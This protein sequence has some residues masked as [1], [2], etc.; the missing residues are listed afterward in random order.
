[1][2]RP[3]RDRDPVKLAGAGML[4]LLG[5]VG[6]AIGL[7][8]AVF[9]QRTTDYAVEL[10]NAAGLRPDDQVFI[11]GVPSGRVRT[12]DLAVDRVR[13]G[14]R[15]DHDQTLGTET[16]AG[17]KLQTILGKRYLDV[18]P[19]GGG[20]IPAGGTIPLAR[21]SVPFSLDDLGRSAAKT[22]EELDLGALKQMI[23]T[24]RANAPDAN[25]AAQALRGV[26]AA[27]S[28][29]DKYSEQL[30][31]LLAGAQSVTS[32]LVSQQD[33]LVA[34]LGD[35]DLIATALV[36]RKA[37]LEKLI[38]DLGTLSTQVRSFLDTNRPMVRPLLDRLQTVA[39]TLTDN[40]EQLG[41]TLDLLAPTGR[42]LA[43]ASGNGPWLD[44][45]GPAGPVPDD[46]LCLFGVV[47]GCK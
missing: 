13:I 33:S 9:Y 3:Y 34:L 26:G 38:T 5:L 27:T 11:A 23:S 14:L 36:E 41:R 6:F 1:M 16:T 18:Q 45:V 37:T 2:R 44:V 24:L 31:S 47:K 22:T 10:A 21:T 46:L 28:V 43:N 25:L 29:F 30:K 19:R 12:V 20:R 39:K 8:Q 42:Y 32:T 40:K 35:T 7:P 15:L 4:V 17:V